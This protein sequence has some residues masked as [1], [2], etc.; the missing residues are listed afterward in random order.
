MKKADGS[1][2]EKMAQLLD[3][4]EYYL[5]LEEAE[6]ADEV[7]QPAAVVATNGNA[8]GGGSSGGSASGGTAQGRLQ[9]AVA[10]VLAAPEFLVQRQSSRKKGKW[11]K[12]KTVVTSTDLRWALQE[13]EACA[14]PAAATAAGVPAEVL[15]SA[16]G[17]G[18]VVVR[19]RT[20]CAN[21]NPVLT[22]ALAISM[23]N[24]AAAAAGSSSS[25]EAV[26]SAD[27]AVEDGNEASSSGDSSNSSGGNSGLYS[28][29]HIHRSDL[30][31]HPMAV[32]QPDFLKLRS[33]LRCGG[34]AV[35]RVLCSSCC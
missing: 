35:S 31:L 14:G 17:S 11:G 16:S 1:N 32:P 18:K 22:P 5:V 10:A 28:L 15:P 23:L 33:L 9:A 29:A 25:S 8:N 24:R 30:R 19:V 26:G 7:A 13:M 2:G 27:V 12:K 20:A 34:G 6:V 3:S 4:V 21:G